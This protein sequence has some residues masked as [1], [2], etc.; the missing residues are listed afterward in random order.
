MWKSMQSTGHSIK[1]IQMAFFLLCLSPPKL[2]DSITIGYDKFAGGVCQVLHANAA[3][4]VEQLLTLGHNN[5]SM[6]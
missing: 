6:C 2:G 5:N 4:R 1:S 3:H